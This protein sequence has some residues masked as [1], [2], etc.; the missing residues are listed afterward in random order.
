M[1]YALPLALVAQAYLLGSIPFSYLVVRLISGDDIRLH[2]SGNVGATNVMRNFGKLPGIIA[3]ALDIAKGW[4][5]TTLA[6]RITILSDWPFSSIYD[7]G[8]LHARTFWI[9]LACLV[10][11]A[12]HMLPIWLRFKGGKGVATAAGAILAVDPLVIAA[13]TIVFFVVVI[14]TRYVSLASIISAASIPFFFRFLAHTSLWINLWSIAIALA[15]IV[16]H[17]QNVRRLVEG[18]ERKF[19]RE[20]SE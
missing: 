16:R 9:G 10:A 11:V 17:H 8:P 1:S 19:G 13:A 2:G 3:L 7:F 18:S 6:A 5:A 4:A 15:V 14:V 12:G 20:K